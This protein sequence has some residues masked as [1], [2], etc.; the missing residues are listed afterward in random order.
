MITRHEAYPELA[1]ALEMKNLFFKREDLHPYGSHKGRSIPVMIDTYI[2][3]GISSFAISSSGNAALA[4][5]FYV[6]KLNQDRQAPE[7]KIRLDILVGQHISTKKLR[8]LEQFKNQ[9]INITMHDRPLQ[10]LFTK[11]KDPMVKGL[12]QSTDD[13]A[14]MGYS[15][16]AE[17]LLEIPNLQAVFIG[18]SSGT[19]A[20][21]LAEYFESKKKKIEVHIVQTSSCHPIADA[22]VDDQL[23]DE[24]SVAD[25]IVDQAAIRKDVI[26]KLLEKSGGSGWVVSNEQINAAQ[27]ITKK[28]AQMDISTNSALSVA[29]LMQGVYTGKAWVGS[30]AC[31]I[32]G[33]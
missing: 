15:A 17:E 21:A 19:T 16:L 1:R 23:L 27:V 7:E 18:T 22:F 32:C 5:A 14:L 33:D 2:S 31:I 30:V 13:T 3:Q 12:R 9:Y 28:H 11:T 8:K 4:A 6:E 26:V 10:T 24:Q 29:G 25:A 20:Q